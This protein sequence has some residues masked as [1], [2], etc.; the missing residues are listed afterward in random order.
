MLHSWYLASI[1]IYFNEKKL[2]RLSMMRAL[3]TTLLRIFWE[4]ILSSWFIFNKA[5]CLNHFKCSQQKKSAWQFW[6]NLVG[7][8][9]AG[10]IFDGEMLRRTFSTILLWLFCKIILCIKVIIIL[11]RASRGCLK[12][13]HCNSMI[14]KNLMALNG[15][16]VPMCL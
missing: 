5:G 2:K 13:Q 14:R 9:K 15:L 16:C 8:S 7:E 4:T 6:W 12:G 11:V 3:P 10:K 1:S